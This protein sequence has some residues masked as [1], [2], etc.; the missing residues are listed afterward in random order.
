V[1]VIEKTGP[2][3]QHIFHLYVRPN[4]V[5]A[6][7][8]DGARSGIQAA[9]D[10]FNADEAGDVN[11][12][13]TLLPHIV[14]EASKVY[15]DNAPIYSKTSKFAA[16]FS[17]SSKEKEG[18]A[19]ILESS[20]VEP[21]RP[22]MNKLRVFKSEA[23][24]ANMR[25]AGQI[26][27]RAY[28]KAMRQAF[29]KEKDLWAFLDYEFKVGGCDGWAY[30]PVVAGGS[31][32]L[33]IH[34]VRNDNVL[35]DDELVLVDAGGEYGGYITDITRTWP[36]GGKFSSPQKDLYEAI[37]KVQ[38]SCVSL[39]RENANLSLD[40]LH[41][42]AEEGLRDNL[43]ALGFDLSGNVSHARKPMSTTVADHIFAES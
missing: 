5:K 9:F 30:V 12:L 25:L 15:T 13:S 34:Y 22:L 20:K 19:K 17:G 31:N 40:G 43:K 4:D 3:G 16:F 33:S 37:L 21:L 36:V 6:E 42:I 41:S 23:E 32:A 27:G 2:E 8:W 29:T 14:A 26:S 24:I 18:F 10:V 28:T 39:C 35:R 7:L 1:A 38:R 11:H